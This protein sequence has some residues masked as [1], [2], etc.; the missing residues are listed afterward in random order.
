MPWKVL[1]LTGIVCT[2]II[3]VI[4]ENHPTKYLSFY[5][6]ISFMLFLIEILL[7]LFSVI[8]LYGVAKEKR[9]ALIPWMIWM[10]IV[11]IIQ[12]ALLIFCVAVVVLF[13]NP[14]FL[15]FLIPCLPLIALNIAC[16]IIVH[17][18]YQRL[19]CSNFEIVKF[20]VIFYNSA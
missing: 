13:R 18:H 11:I 16:I 10:I 6:M 12:W 19:C 20:Y 8:L 3:L 17:K 14:V 9:I 4:S 5:E 7:F 15:S 1:S 2:T